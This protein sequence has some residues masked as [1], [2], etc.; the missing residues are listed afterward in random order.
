MKIPNFIKN[1][2]VLLDTYNFALDAHTNRMEDGKPQLRKFSGVPYIT[3]PVA[4][5][6]VLLHNN[7]GDLGMWQAALL[8]DVVEDTLVELPEIRERFGE[9]V[10]YLVEGLTKKSL[11]SP[12]S[13]AIRKEMDREA[14]ASYCARV[15]TVKVADIYHNT[16]SAGSE[17][18]DDWAMMWLNE[19]ESLLS[20]LMLADENLL[21]RTIELVKTA[22]K[23]RSK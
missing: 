12:D 19:A 8:H 11:G 20:A 9:D 15:Q 18:K 7:L 22:K 2:P 17:G 13:R 21:D 5:L 4:V 10:A 3:H 1:H 16:L 6:G 14:Y 23:F